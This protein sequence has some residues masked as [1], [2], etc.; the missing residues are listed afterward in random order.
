MRMDSKTRPDSPARR[1]ARASR[2]EFLLTSAAAGAA[3]SFLPGLGAVPGAQTGR[4]LAPSD[5]P[6]RLALIGIGNRGLDL[7]KSFGTTGLVEVVALCDVDLDGSHT[8]E[9]QA[10]HPNATR[11]RDFR[12][13]FDE[14]APAFDA[15]VIATPDHSHCP[16]ALVAMAHGK[17]VYV[18][19]PLAQTFHEVDLL[20]AAAARTG[21]VTQMGNQGH[22]GNNYFQFKA[23]TEAGVIK[24]V[25]K[26]VAFM[27]SERRW[28][29]WKI[30][31][32]PSGE[33]LPPGLDWD[34]WHVG[35]QVQPFSTRLHPLT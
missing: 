27:N 15:A 8:Q 29:G 24:D 2:R 5:R 22:S 10:L 31:G 4:P 13:L 23:W 25:T 35:R 28:H 33:P 11:V 26:I 20:M 16:L 30:D 32:F 12:T 7:I 3:W 9:A 34:L 21:V 6:L 19:K 18:E 14:S 1:F 17:H